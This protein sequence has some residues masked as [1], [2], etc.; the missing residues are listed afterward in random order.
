MNRELWPLLVSVLVAVGAVGCTSDEIDENAGAGSRLTTSGAGQLL[1]T[2]TSAFEPGNPLAAL[3]RAAPNGPPLDEITADMLGVDFGTEEAPV[4][5]V[6]F[7]DYGCGYCKLFHEET[8]RPLHE[9][10]VDRGSVFWK[11]I[12]FITGIWAASMPISLAAECARD[13]GQSYFVSISDIIFERQ[14]DWKS[15]SDPEALAESFAEEAGLDMARYRS[16]FEDDQFLWRVQAQTNLA[17]ELGIRGTP[18]FV[19]VGM[20]PINGALPLET[21]RQVLD[22][23]LSEVAARQF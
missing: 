4:R 8:R 12:P 2:G 15:A 10:Y 11:S 21:F 17:G 6:E 22:T 20:G 23:I 5:M 7:Y 13:Q 19:I 1:S 9:E 16:C 14:G 3:A 18:T